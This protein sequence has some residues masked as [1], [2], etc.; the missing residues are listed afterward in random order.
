MNDA[1][2]NAHSENMAM[3]ETVVIEVEPV[4]VM[5]TDASKPNAKEVELSE[6][7]KRK[8]IIK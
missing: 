3:R 8:L 7:M 6:D 2:E 1:K 5:R 4:K